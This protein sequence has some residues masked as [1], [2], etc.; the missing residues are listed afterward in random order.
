MAADRGAPAGRPVLRSATEG[1]SPAADRSNKIRPVVLAGGTGTRLWPMSRRLHPKQFLPLASEASLLQETVRRVDDKARFASPLVVCNAAHRFLVAEQL[2]EIGVRPEAIL[3]EPEG[4]NTAPAAATAAL[5]LGDGDRDALMLVLPSDHVIGK[6]EAFH[7]AVDTGAAAARAGALVTFG[8]R[9]EAPETGFGYIR[10][11]AALDG[12][13]GCYRVTR[14]VEKPERE[15]AERYLAEGD[16]YWN[17]GIFLFSA[18]RYLEELERL[19]PAMVTACRK[20]VER[21]ARDP[22]FLRLDAAAFGMAPALSI[23]HAVMEATTAAAAVVPVDMAWSDIGSWSALWEIGAKDKDGNV[24]VGDVSAHGVKGSYIRGEGLLVA[25]VGLEDVVIVA[26]DDA[27]LAAAKDRVQEVKGIVEAL[28]AE[29]R[30]E[31]ASHPKV[32]RPWGHYQTV[33]AGKGFQVKRIT[34]NPGHKLSLQKHSRRSE[35]WV[36]VEGIARVTR[37]EEVLELEANQSTYIPLGMAH[38]LENPGADPLQLIEVQYGDYLGEDDIVR[39]E[40]SYGRS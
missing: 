37:G 21:A 1:G 6:V 22:D 36:V 17:S 40:D 13:P 30:A 7:E 2:R 34:V 15:A 38:R 23:D 29:G 25:A 39:L 28:K 26:T 20:A 11:G 27:V 24:L 33:D 5:V 8:V 9:A 19:Q 32:Y 31:A 12:A 10:R 4:R 3:I 16:H 14:F 18:R 35:H